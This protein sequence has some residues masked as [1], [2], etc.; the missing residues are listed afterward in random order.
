MAVL[1]DARILEYLFD[2]KLTISPIIYDHIQPSSID[3]TLDRIIKVPKP[4]RIVN[5]L[6]KTDDCFDEVSIETYT[7][8]PGGFV[9][10]QI[11]ERL[12]IPRNLMGMIQN[13]NSI[14]RLGLN[15]GLSTYINPG[16][17]GQ[18]PIAIHN[19]GALE[20]P[21]IPG[22][23][24]CQLVLLDVEPEPHRD[25]SQRENSKYQGESGYLLSKIY[26]EPELKEF[27]RKK[28]NGEN[29]DSISKFLEQ[30]LREKSKD[31]REQ[32]SEEEL[33]EIELL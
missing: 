32:L 26:E 17:E 31:I 7:L 3:L 20:V 2:K 5:M 1:S 14:V 19:I 10:A 24:I 23:R 16:Y 21:L 13:R 11:R 28:K 29:V 8:R 9:M 33:R 27:L 22:M 6:D 12:K 15:L 30:R 25:Y 4:G 18:L